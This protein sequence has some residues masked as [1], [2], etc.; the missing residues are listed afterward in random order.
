MPGFSPH[1]VHLA[2]LLLVALAGAATS[3][4]SFALATSHSVDVITVL[5]VVPQL[6]S[7]LVV[8]L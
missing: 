1:N 6:P 4:A 2:A 3:C 8:Q 5:V 7:T